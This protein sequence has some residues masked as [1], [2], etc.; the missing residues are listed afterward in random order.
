MCWASSFK[1]FYYLRFMTLVIALIKSWV[2]FRKPFF[3]DQTGILPS[4]NWPFSRSSMRW[5][6]VNEAKKLCIG[7]WSLRWRQK[8]STVGIFWEGCKIW[9]KI[10]ILFEITWY[11]TSKWIW[12]VFKFL[13]AFLEYLNFNI[14]GKRYIFSKQNCI[15]DSLVT[16][17]IHHVIF[18]CNFAYKM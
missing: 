1:C 7:C 18:L 13:V 9:K 12:R 16:C 11:I 17:Q 6:E 15:K 2:P 4:A 8:I 5:F 14:I 3:N 10:W